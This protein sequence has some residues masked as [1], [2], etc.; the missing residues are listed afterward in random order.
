MVMVQRGSD[1]LV[2]TS[3]GLAVREV[4]SASS[5]FWCQAVRGLRVCGQRATNLS[6]VVG[7]SASAESSET[8]SRVPPE[9]ELGPAPRLPSCFLTAPSLFCTPPFPGRQQFE[10][11]C[12]N[13]GKV[14]EAE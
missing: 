8:V 2:D 4:E 3:N 13:S 1:Q 6:Y 5:A 11:A 12:W 10:P 7:V 14:V 9:G